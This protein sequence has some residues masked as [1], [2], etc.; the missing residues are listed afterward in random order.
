M[1]AC[2]CAHTYTYPPATRVA[3]S[4]DQSTE[5]QSSKALNNQFHPN[6]CATS[7]IQ[8][9]T[10][11]SW[12]LILFVGLANDEPKRFINSCTF[13][14]SHIIFKY[15]LCSCHFSYLQWSGIWTETNWKITVSL[16]TYNLEHYTGIHQVTRYIR[17]NN[18]TSS[19]TKS[20][21]SHGMPVQGAW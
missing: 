8:C 11:A 16:Q 10:A 15:I 13:F 6:S 4:H 3:H 1:H 20:W 14:W 7:I 21:E 17:L 12:A 5:T 2:T 9:G 19:P 18:N